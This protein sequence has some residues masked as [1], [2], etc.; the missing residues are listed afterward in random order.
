MSHI[1]DRRHSFIIWLRICRLSKNTPATQ[2]LQL[3]IDAGTGT[4]PAAD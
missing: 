3:S 4:P 1:A 2:A